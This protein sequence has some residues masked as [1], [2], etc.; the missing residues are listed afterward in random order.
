[1]RSPTIHSNIGC[2]LTSNPT[3]SIF[4]LP[5]E[6][7]ERI[8]THCRIPDV[9]AFARTCCLAYLLILGNSSP[10]IMWKA[11]FLNN[12]DDPCL[13]RP[14]DW[15]DRAIQR[16][17]AELHAQSPNSDALETFITAIHEAAP[18]GPSTQSLNIEWLERT[19]KTT[20]E[21]LTSNAD[22]PRSQAM[23]SA[24]LRSYTGLSCDPCNAERARVLTFERRRNS[25]LYVYNLHNYT[26]RHWGPFSD[27][28]KVDWIHLEHLINV[29]IMNFRELPGPW[30][31]ICPP[32]GLRATRKYSA[33]AND[34][35]DPRDWAKVSGTWRRYVSYMD[36]RSVL[37]L[38]YAPN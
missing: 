8:L 20:S 33:P 6:I 25:R 7:I 23:V 2:D 28:G 5:L 24:Q 11:I 32:H 17:K 18:G 15:K 4:P 16:L 27:D 10:K 9:I 12:F 1:M 36:F 31:R 35:E 37:N 30:A 21:V 26:G 3:E 38:V 29:L 34:L 13:S 22:V 19:L 14:V